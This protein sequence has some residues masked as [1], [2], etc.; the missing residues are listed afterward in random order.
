[1]NIQLLIIMAAV[2]GVL[3]V[4]VLLRAHRLRLSLEYTEEENLQLRL[5]MHFG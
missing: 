4:V 5:V 1:M 3:L 2:L